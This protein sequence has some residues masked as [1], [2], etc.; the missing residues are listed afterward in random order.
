M[1]EGSLIALY[2][3]RV[4]ASLIHQNLE[5]AGVSPEMIEKQ[6][7]ICSSCEEAA[8]QAHGVAVLSEWDE[9]REVD[10]DKVLDSMFKPAYHLRWPRYS[11][12]RSPEN[13][14]L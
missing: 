14:G 8:E 11:R 10:F 1:M 4:P 5:Y 12:S 13:H 7:T 3:P 9:F 6:L 2:D